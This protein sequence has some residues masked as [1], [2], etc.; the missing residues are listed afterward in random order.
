MLEISGK[1]L[2]VHHEQNNNIYIHV[3]IY[4]VLEKHKHKNF[5]ALCVSFF[6]NSQI[7]IFSKCS[8][9]YS[10]ASHVQI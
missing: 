4:V 8:I 1:D 3:Y 9:M 2:E 7:M 6:L 5:E 10:D